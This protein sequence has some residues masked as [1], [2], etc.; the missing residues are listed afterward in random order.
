MLFEPLLPMYSYYISKILWPTFNNLLLNISTSSLWG[1]LLVFDPLL[2]ALKRNKTYPIL[3]HQRPVQQSNTTVLHLIICSHLIHNQ[4]NIEKTESWKPT[5]AFWT[6]PAHST[7]YK[8][9]FIALVFDD[10]IWDEFCFSFMLQVMGRILGSS[11]IK[12]LLNYSVVN[13]SLIHIW[14]CRR[15]SLCRSR[16]SP[17]H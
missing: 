8:H 7:L 17:Y 5:A 2:K 9:T 6:T 16:W 10:L 1:F 3:D 11:P 12:N 15:Y 4:H 13:L 14:R